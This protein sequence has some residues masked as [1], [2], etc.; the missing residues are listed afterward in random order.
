MHAC[1]TA[2]MHGWART[3]IG[4]LLRVALCVRRYAAELAVR[5]TTQ[6]AQLYPNCTPWRIRF[7]ERKRRCAYRLTGSS[8]RIRLIWK[9]EI[10]RQGGLFVPTRCRPRPTSV[11]ALRVDRCAGPALSLT[12]HAWS[13]YVL[14]L[15]AYSTMKQAL[16]QHGVMNLQMFIRTSKDEMYR[17][18]RF[19]EKHARPR[20]CVSTVA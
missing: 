4:M 17:S 20:H 15:F 19:C 9:R 16:L 3:S 11:Q 7:R 8:W 6:A 5:D 14:V 12:T 18:T 2:C 10:E 13:V 1:W